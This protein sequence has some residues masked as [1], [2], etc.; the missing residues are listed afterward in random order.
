[1]RIHVNR[2][3]IALLPIKHLSIAY[4]FIFACA[5][6]AQNAAAQPEYNDTTHF[7]DFSVHYTFFPSTFIQPDIASAYNIK[8]SKYEILINIS[9]TNPGE[10]GGI[11]AK[12]RGT[13]TNLMQQQKS[14]SIVEIKEKDVTYYLAP[15]HIAAKE[16]V[17]I[18]LYVTPEGHTETKHIK[19]TKTLYPQ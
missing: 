12:I 13:T 18:D 5:L 19:I 11:A 6:C 17:H 4:F 10:Y 16:I 15:V 9:V 3:S 8:R 2:F 1:M 7:D 14:L